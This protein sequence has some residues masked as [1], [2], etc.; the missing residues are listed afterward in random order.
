MVKMSVKKDS[1]KDEMIQIFSNTLG[2]EELAA[3]RDVFKSKWIG[4]GPI[5]KEFERAFAEKIGSKHFLLYNS[6]TSATFSAVE[7]L[8]IKKGDEVILP[9]VNFIGC[10]NAVIK[11]GARPVFCDV[12]PDYYNVTAEEIEDKRTERT[13]A[14]I[15]IHYG[16]HPID[17]KSVAKASEGLKIIEDSANSPHSK[18]RGRNCGTLGDAGAYS[19]DAMK[20]ICIGNGGGLA[21]QDDELHQ[22]AIENRYFGLP[23][24]GKSG[25]DKMAGGKSRWWEIELNSVSGRHISNDILAAIALAQMDKVDAFVERRKEIWEIYKEQLTGQSWLELP[26]EPLAGTDSSYYLFW[27]RI[28]GGK[29][30]KFARFMVANN[31]YV[32]FR[33]FPLHLIQYYRK[34]HDARVSLP[35]SER[36]NE[37]TI[38][39]PIH[40]NLTDADVEK[41]VRKIKEFG[42]REF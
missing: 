28:K 9:S 27:L 11:V 5:T 4:S 23:P 12:D 15:P 17:F 31:I 33:Y 18:Y 21:V 37:T 16:G 20:Y 1:K 42:R 22:K 2:E 38:N 34:H 19:F 29:R 30:D 35:V 32:T 3:I 7:I 14:V 6:A 8:G 10:A 25:I 13:K 39:I 24:K 36:I 26:P 40:Q 41:V